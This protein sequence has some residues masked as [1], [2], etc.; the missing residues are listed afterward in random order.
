MTGK[1]LLE[2]E[3]EGEEET[4]QSIVGVFGEA[5]PQL[6]QQFHSERWDAYIVIHALH[7]LHSPYPPSTVFTM[8]LQRNTLIKAKRASVTG[9]SIT[10]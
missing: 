7:A 9:N 10:R 3:I 6:M 1:K 8:P 2:K 5:F 4:V